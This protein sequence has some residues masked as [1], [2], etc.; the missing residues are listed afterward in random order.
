[1]LL[2]KTTCILALALFGIVGSAAAQATGMPAYH[3]PYRSF[4][5]HEVGVA[6]S[7]PDYDGFALEGLFGFGYREFDL[8]ARGGFYDPG[9]LEETQVILGL[10]G[11]YRVLTHTEDF[12]LDGAVVTGIGA[13][14]DGTS[15]ALIPIGLSLGRRLNVEDSEVSIVPYVEPVG[16]I[17]TAGDDHFAFGLGLGADFRLS[18]KF[19]AR[20]SVA[21]GDA[22]LEGFSIGAVWV[23]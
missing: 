11:R 16:L 22:P 2:R 10:S 3:A 4:D 13:W 20:L 14:F 23:N 1:M 15:T 7:F 5:R 6:V 21:F 18:R 12:P 17:V 19:D 9:E 8:E